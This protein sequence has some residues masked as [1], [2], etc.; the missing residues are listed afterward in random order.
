MNTSFA[1]TRRVRVTAGL[2]A[3]GAF[4]AGVTSAEEEKSLAQQIFDT[5]VQVHGVA[6][7]YRVVHAK[8]VVCQGTFTPSKDAELLMRLMVLRI[9][10][11]CNWSASFSSCDRPALLAESPTSPW[12]ETSRLETSPSEPS[13]VPMT[14][15][16]RCALERYRGRRIVLAPG[17]DR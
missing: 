16:A 8:G 12:S 5:M 11:T 6:P 15:S 13:A 10:S 14:L 1:S 3:A 2:L 4:W 7:G 9:E 17:R